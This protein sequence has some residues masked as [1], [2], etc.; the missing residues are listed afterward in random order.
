MEIGWWRAIALGLAVGFWSHAAAAEPS[1]AD[2]KEARVRYDRAIKLYRQRAYESALVEFQKAYE[3]APSYR[4]DYNIAQVYQELGDPAGAMRSLQR[5]LRDGGNQLTGSKRKRAEQELAG[6]RTKVAELAI[7]ANLEGAEVTVNDVVLGTTPLPEEV[8]VNPG[9]HRV[10]V[11]YPGRIPAGKVIA[12]VAG[13]TVE[14]DLALVDPAKPAPQP[15][16]ATTPPTAVAPSEPP[17]EPAPTWIGWTTTGVLAAGAVVTGA[18]HL[19]ARSDYDAERDSLG[20]E[21]EAKQDAL[22]AAHDRARNYAI[23]TDI[24]AAT[25]LVAGGLTL[26][27][28]LQEG[29]TAETAV[30]IGPGTVAWSG[31]F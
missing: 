17:R 9:R 24:L 19:S 30:G 11:T 31:R 10:Q 1:A 21:P 6:L 28:T 16:R 18:L 7:R 14:V 12:A 23:A 4:I 26:Y 5:H 29:S 20:T 25:A 8:W 27:V 22:V 13:E 3:L 2:V 15:A